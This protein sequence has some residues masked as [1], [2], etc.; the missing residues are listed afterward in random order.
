MAF[1]LIDK[2]SFHS[3]VSRLS[4]GDHIRRGNISTS[5]GATARS[6]KI[7]KTF[8]PETEDDCSAVICTVSRLVSSSLANDEHDANLD[9]SVRH[10]HR[11]IILH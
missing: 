11:N 1:I 4:P 9:C 7:K 5:R 8:Q 10:A 2:S 3:S 6:A